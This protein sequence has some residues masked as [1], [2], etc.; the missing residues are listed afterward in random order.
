MASVTISTLYTSVNSAN[1][2]PYAFSSQGFPQTLSINATASVRGSTTGGAGITNS[3][4]GYSAFSSQGAGATNP[5]ASWAVTAGSNTQ[6]L[7]ANPSSLTD[8][9]HN[10]WRA[11]LTI[12]TENGTRYAAV[13]G[14]IV[15]VAPSASPSNL[16]YPSS[17]AYNATS[18]TL[19]I[20]SPSNHAF[21][22][23]YDSYP[24]DPPFPDTHPDIAGFQPSSFSVAGPTSYGTS[25]NY[26]IFDALAETA[27][28]AGGNGQSDGRDWFFLFGITVTRGTPDTTPSFSP[29]DFV[30]K[31]GQPLSTTVQSATTLTVSGLDVAVNISISGAGGQY[32]YSNGSYSSW[33]SYTTN[34]VIGNGTTIQ[35]R[36]NSSS[37]FNTT[38]TTTL[39]VGGA[40]GSNSETFSIT[41]LAQDVTPNQF[42]IGANVSNAPLSTNYN[43][44]F[45]IAGINSPVTVTGS[46]GALVSTTNGSGY[47]TSITRSNGQT[48]YVRITSSS[49]FSTTVN[50]TVTIGTV[51]DTRSI[52]TLAQ[53]VTP[54]QF[55]VGANLTNQALG[56]AFISSFTVAGVNT[57]VTASRTGASLVG[58][59]S[60]GPWVTSISRTNGQTVYMR[61]V[62]SSSANTSVTGG[63]T[64]GTISDSRTITTGNGDS[65]PS[66]FNL[67]ANATN[68]AVSGQAGSSTITVAGVN[69]GSVVPISISKISSESPAGSVQYSVNSGTPTSSAGSVSLGDNVSVL[70]TC[71][72]GF[73]KTTTARLNIGGITDD[74]SATTEASTSGSVDPGANSA[75]YGL[76]VF[77][78][79]STTILDPTDRVATLAGVITSSFTSGQTSKTHTL[80]R[81][82]TTVIRL[83][84]AYTITTA[85]TELITA[86][87]SGTTL[88]VTRAASGSAKSYSFLVINE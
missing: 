74:F 43:S 14:T 75:N 25:R 53:D 60:S 1:A 78:S 24:G 66:A 71:S 15:D 4:L 87:V 34:G 50:G 39:T 41:T 64:I 86:S 27:G 79:S 57:T 62:S 58:T 5:L 29:S 84:P 70:I 19:S 33:R 42:N 23:W 9:T 46:S 59:S 7:Y 69:S 28:G 45:T 6:E 73:S 2:N 30:D 35:V 11:L 77:N 3:T 72:S 48:V 17:I 40:Y 83:N 56:T 80:S 38:T 16:S 65:T 52:T 61:L 26:Y 22:L 47:T 44:S 67:G 18:F 20:S 55:S 13:T 85:K 54:T 63:V 10:S 81:S 12:P 76:R 36:A 21:G 49:N 37:S 31:T 88:T 32:R 51:S 8:R 68:V 82:G